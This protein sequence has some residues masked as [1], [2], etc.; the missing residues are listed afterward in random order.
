M[1][2]ENMTITGTI[3]EDGEIEITVVCDDCEETTFQWLNRNEIIKLRD[4][5][6]GILE[7]K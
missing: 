3:D 6:N 4:H 7:S 2:L 1:E 5:L